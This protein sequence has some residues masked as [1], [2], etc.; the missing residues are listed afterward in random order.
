M[1]RK[2]LRDRKVFSERVGFFIFYGISLYKIFL[3]GFLLD[4]I[5]ICFVMGFLMLVFRSN[6]IFMLEFYFNIS[7]KI[8]GYIMFYNGLVGGFFGILV[9]KIVKFYNYNDVKM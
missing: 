6:F 1:D 2:E 7:L 9:G 3:I 4:L 8:N 5:V